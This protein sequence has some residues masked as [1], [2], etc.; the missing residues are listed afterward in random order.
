M[1]QGG[2]GM[3]TAQELKSSQ[4]FHDISYEEYRRI[5]VYKRQG[6]THIQKTKAVL[7]A[8]LV[9]ARNRGIA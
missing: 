7:W 2:A 5:D 3:L 1:Q 6:L 4:L 8:A 9:F